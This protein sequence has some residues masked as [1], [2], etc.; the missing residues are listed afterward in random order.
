MLHRLRNEC[1]RCSL[2]LCC[3]LN[4][5]SL[6]TGLSIVGWASPRVALIRDSIYIEGGT[7]YIGEYYEN[8]TINTASYAYTD[9]GPYGTLYK[10]NLTRPFNA[11]NATDAFEYMVPTQYDPGAPLMVDGAIFASEYGFYTYG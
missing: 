5:F 10:L 1:S 11:T 3:F 7:R 2:L 6:V 4:P 8:G 9:T